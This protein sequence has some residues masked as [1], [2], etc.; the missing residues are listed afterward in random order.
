M[1][2]AA[3]DSRTLQWMF[4]S[5][6]LLCSSNLLVSCDVV[7]QDD[8]YTLANVNVTYVDPLTKL[9]RSK[10]DEIGKYGQ[11]LV[12]SAA[13]VVIHVRTQNGTSNYG[14]EENFDNE[15]PVEAPWIALVKHGNCSS[16]LKI[17]NAVRKNASAIV[18][19]D[20]RPGPT[21]KMQTG[22]ETNYFH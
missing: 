21:Q 9:H 3:L 16:H 19:Y 12:G 4:V 10:K 11:G 8:D 1:T 5:L 6:S 14:C 2:T 17:I 22:G 13:G 20:D 7:S 15:I 18:V